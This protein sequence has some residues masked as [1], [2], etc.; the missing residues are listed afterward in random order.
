MCGHTNSNWPIVEGNLILCFGIYLYER[1]PI[2]P[3]QKHLGIGGSV[4]VKGKLMV[5]M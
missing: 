4:N 3:K 5:F 2:N 1:G